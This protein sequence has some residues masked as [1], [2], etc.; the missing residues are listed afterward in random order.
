MAD[1]NSSKEGKPEEVMLTNV[2]RR[3]LLL[4]LPGQ[5]LRF[6]PGDQQT[7]LKSLLATTEVRRMCEQ[8]FVVASP[9]PEPE[10]EA[11]LA[12]PEAT[13]S[14]S[15]NTVEVSA[16]VENPPEVEGATAEAS[17]PDSEGEALARE[18]N[19][20][21]V[22]EVTESDDLRTEAQATPSASETNLNERKPTKS[23]TEPRE[24]GKRLS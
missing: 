19:E 22:A 16:A 8:R 6:G 1:T 4:R 15:E 10:V 24:A 13:T 14:S 3:P 18:G 7:V 20:A 23:K 2:S 21:A 5:T 17:E 12:G 11:E 9:I